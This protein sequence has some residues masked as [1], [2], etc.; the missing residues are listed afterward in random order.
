MS[1]R[2]VALAWVIA[3]AVNLAATTEARACATC[4]CGDPTLTALGAE[5]PYRNRVRASVEGRLRTDRIGAPDVDQI[6]LNEQR[7]DVQGAWAPHERLFLLLTVPVMRRE[8]SNVNLARR[9]TL[10]LGDVELRGK[11]FLYQDSDDV[12]RHLVSAIGGVKFPTAPLQRDGTGRLL[13]IELQPGTG[14]VDPIVGLSY[15]FF[16]RPWSAYASVQGFFPT[17]GTEGYRASAALRSTIAVQ[18]QI[19]PWIAS[20]L[21]VDTRLDGKALEAGAS[22]RDSGGFIG[23]VSPEVLVSPM[24][25]VMLYASVRIPVVQALA[26]YHRE[27]PIYT[28]GAAVD[29]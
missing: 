29:F 10:G 6:R 8:V 5:K 3:L 20:R 17:K 26:G 11:V 12:P 16:P 7:V 21:A 15:A 25:D 13:P 4:G 2:R 24:T 18:Y 9:L 27:G 14:S 28:L 1:A 23:F 22:E 19:K